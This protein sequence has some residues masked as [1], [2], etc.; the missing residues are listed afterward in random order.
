[1]GVASLLLAG[2]VTLSDHHSL[3]AS[4]IPQIWYWL[5]VFW[6]GLALLSFLVIARLWPIMLRKLGG[7]DKDINDY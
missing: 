7:E 1:M 2:L 4:L 6:I 3:F 5:L